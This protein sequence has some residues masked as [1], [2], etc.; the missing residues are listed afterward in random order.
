MIEVQAQAHA[1]AHAHAQA[2]AHAY[3]AHALDILISFAMHKKSY[4][5]GTC[6]TWTCVTF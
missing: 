6:T 4:R 5:V 3:I 2:Y 1:H